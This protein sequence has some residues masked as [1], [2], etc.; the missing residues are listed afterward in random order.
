MSALHW[1]RL[2]I[3]ADQVDDAER[4]RIATANRYR[5]LIDDKHLA[6]S[7]ESKAL[8]A[9]LEAVK[10][11]ERIAVLELKRAMRS[12]PLGEWCKAQIGVGEKTLARLLGVIGDPAYRLDPETG[13]LHERTL[14]QLR[15]YCG[16]GDA[17]LQKRRKG[18]KANWNAEARKRLYLIAECC[19]KQ[20]DSPYRKVYD[21]TRA[22]YADA[23]HGDDCA[24]CGPSGKPAPAGSPLSDGHKHARAL[25]AISK[26]FLADLWREARRVQVSDDNQ[27]RL[28]AAGDLLWGKRVV[29]TTGL[30]EPE[31]LAA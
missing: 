3:A 21:D 22:K 2:T 13:E 27:A 24:R 31:E 20:T 25:R 16:Y 18:Q 28:D 9:Q 11:V 19:M 17:A 10:A 14:S 5:A 8:E 26:I 29:V 4:L 7:P 1:A 6:D 12:H 23:V 30:N 15:S